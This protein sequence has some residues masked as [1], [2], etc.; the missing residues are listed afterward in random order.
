MK[1]NYLV[2]ILIVASLTGNANAQTWQL[3]SKA[4]GPGSDYANAI[5]IDNSGN[6]YVTGKF[7]DSISFDSISLVTPDLWSVYI[8][9][10]DAG[11]N[12]IWAKVAASDSLISVVS[13]NI[14]KS[15]NVS[16][17][18]QYF[19][20]ATFGT[21]AAINLISSA[22]YDVFVAKYDTVGNLLW[23]K[24]LGGQGIDYSGGVGTDNADNIYVTGD[25]HISSFPYSGSKI[26]LAKY[27]SSGNSV[28]LKTSAN[29][30]TDHF[31]NGIKVDSTGNSF[32]TGEFFNTLVFDSSAV[33]DAGNVESN[34]FLA[35]FDSS[36]T[37]L[38]GQKS[39]AASGYCGSK[40]IDIDHAGNSYF[41]GYYHGTISFG[42]LSI[43]STMGLANEV[44]IA[45]CDT[46]GNFVW[47][48]KSIGAGSSRNIGLDQAGNILISGIF[49]QNISFGLSSL[50][51]AGSNDVFV[52]E[53][54][55]SGNFTWAT[56]CGGMHNDYSGGLKAN[57]N[58]ITIAGYFSDT[59]YFGTSLNL[60]ANS[61]NNTDIFLSVLNSF[62]GIE[63][64]N[65]GNDA[66]VFP[67]P[68]TNN[69]T[70]AFMSAGKRREV[71]ITDIAGKIIYH[72]KAVTTQ[73]LEVDTKYFSNG[74]YVVQIYTG[75]IMETRKLIVAKIN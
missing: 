63:E 25:F 14:D 51:S 27:D 40:A 26:F 52:S 74:V 32:I 18:G 70:I 7:F 15:G 55:P 39:G 10:Y 20:T 62:T 11:G 16:I 13:I 72:C 30:G 31:G 5:D 6:S 50:T 8:A 1:K 47:V 60:V 4:G 58:G 71:T 24:S 49:S 37:I 19:A 28:W 42:A 36:G 61:S 56:S 44:Y 35:K 3:A 43:T 2:K 68:A 9:K 67:N 66:N 33:I 22:D 53:V 46:A 29:Y 17:S 41:T 69:F 34:S 64:V 57:T 59:I 65:Q 73:Q 54:N 12:V 38:W 48:N 23:A 45:K 75:D 21:A